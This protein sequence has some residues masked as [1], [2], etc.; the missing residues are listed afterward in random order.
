[1]NENVD[2]LLAV[3]RMKQIMVSMEIPNRHI[4]VT[5]AI[6]A[7][8]LVKSTSGLP[9][10]WRHCTADDSQIIINIIHHYS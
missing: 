7:K 5:M 4:L 8:I 6:G 2:K 10:I 9:K 3:S 1:M